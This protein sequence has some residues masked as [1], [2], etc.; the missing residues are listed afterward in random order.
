MLVYSGDVDGIVPVVGTRRW[1]ASLRLLE[2]EPWGPWLVDDQV[3]FRGGC[4]ALPVE[5]LSKCQPNAS[6]MPVKCQASRQHWS[7]RIEP[8]AGPR[9]AASHWSASSGFV[10]FAFAFAC[11]GKAHL[12]H[13]MAAA[14]GAAAGR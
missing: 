14:G 5:R 9:G 4:A 7:L 2:R 8:H 13:H 11:N 3:R 6:Q 1:V 10:A 12:H